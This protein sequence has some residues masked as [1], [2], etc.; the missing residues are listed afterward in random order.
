MVVSHKFNIICFTTSCTLTPIIGMQTLVVSHKLDTKL[1]AYHNLCRS[2]QD[3]LLR[4]AAFQSLPVRI[5]QMLNA[6]AAVTTSTSGFY[7]QICCCLHEV[8]LATESTITLHVSSTCPKRTCSWLVSFL[9]RCLKELLKALS[10]GT[11]MEALTCL[12][13]NST[14]Y[15]EL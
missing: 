5:R 4:S 1:F 6:E 11:A 13:S 10:T 7:S 9:Q 2:S 15:L 14:V 3:L 8:V 12:D